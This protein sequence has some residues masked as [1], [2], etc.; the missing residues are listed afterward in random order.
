MLE[1]DYFTTFVCSDAF[2][3]GFSSNSCHCSTRCS[4]T[5]TRLQNRLLYITQLRGELDHRQHTPRRLEVGCSFRDRYGKTL[6]GWLAILGKKP[7]KCTST[8]ATWH[9]TQLQKKT[10]LTSRFNAGLLW[11]LLLGSIFPFD[12]LR[13]S[14][15]CVTE[16]NLN[17]SP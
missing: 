1:T 5:F 12:W 4:C 2:S 13:I 6:S 14:P 10:Y 15:D 8:S 17:L 16:A 9:A 3:L 11:S 7:F